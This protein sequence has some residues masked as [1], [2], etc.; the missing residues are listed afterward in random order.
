MYKT[1]SSECDI[2]NRSLFLQMPNPEAAILV[3]G[4][5]ILSGRT[6]DKNIGWLAEELTALGISLKEARVIADDRETIIQT[7]RSLAAT[8][9]YVF[10]SGGI[11]PTHDDITTEAVAAAFGVPVI[12]HPEAMARL[13]RHYKDTDIDFNE[14]RQ[15]MADIPETA[16]LID[17]PVSAAPGYRIENVHVMAGV[18]SILQ[19]MF[20]GLAPSLQGG[21]QPT[22]ITVQCA[23]G[24]GTIA[25]ILG[26]VSDQFAGVSIGSYPWFKPGQF[27]TA[28]V[29][30]GLEIADVEAAAALV[31]QK[32]EA[33][34]FAAKRDADNSIIGG[35]GIGGS[36]IG[37]SGIGGSGIGG[38]HE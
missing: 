33:E 8:Y 32:V 37:G 21:V 27:G 29:L 16:E 1:P 7:V 14:A 34:G 5:E 20:K 13:T 10:T 26:A 17:N 11:G 3:I 18:P 6:K 30:T 38:G 25:G 9:D 22:R 12:R 23:I 35:S 28:V 19:A 31:A 4:D 36:G 24:E 2:A 15:K